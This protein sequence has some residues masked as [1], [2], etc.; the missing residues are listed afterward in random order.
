MRK[1][2]LLLVLL[3]IS[4]IGCKADKTSKKENTEKENVI[5]IITEGMDIQMPDSISSGWH[6]FRY[7]NNSKDV[8]LIL[9]DKYP[10]GITI[11]NTEHEVAPAFQKGMNLIT[12]GKPE[13]GF[14]EFNKLPAWF[15][16]VVFSGGIGLISPDRI[17]ET[18]MKLEPGYYVVECYVK[19]PNGIFHTTM[20]MATELVVT[21]KKSDGKELKADI[22]INISGSEGITYD[23]MFKKGEQVVSVYFEDQK[24]HEHF[25]GH[26]INLV[27]IDKGAE[28]SVLENWINWADPKGLISPAPDGFTF[29][30]GVNDMPKGSKGYFKINLKVGNYAL[31]AEVPNASSKNMLKT[32]SIV[33]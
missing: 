3:M 22:N 11:K 19:M 4:L 29:L 17:T 12:E 5:N 27:K 26:D 23:E 28:I 25:L 9:F 30:G 21:D 18:T 6:T 7:N 1:S 20:G 32:F 33:E 10:D 14:A 8:H 13:E 16:N 2:F 31:I 15:F 24:V